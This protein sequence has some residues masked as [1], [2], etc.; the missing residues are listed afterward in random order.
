MYSS[1]GVHSG[2]YDSQFLPEK[3]AF[4]RKL[5]KTV[6]SMDVKVAKPT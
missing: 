1:R 5:A 3:L 6:M 2:K 4:Q